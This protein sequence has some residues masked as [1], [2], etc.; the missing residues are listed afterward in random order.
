[1]T[2]YE[3]HSFTCS[4]ELN[5]EVNKQKISHERSYLLPILVEIKN[6]LDEH[7]VYQYPF[8]SKTMTSVELK[9]F[10]LHF[11]NYM[12]LPKKSK[13]FLKKR[14]I[15]KTNASERNLLL[16]RYVLDYEKLIINFLPIFYKNHIDN[17]Q[18]NQKKFIEKFTENIQFVKNQIPPKVENIDISLNTFDMK[19][20]EMVCDNDDPSDF[21]NDFYFQ[22]HEW[23][24]M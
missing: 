8:F 6:Y 15:N 9:K 23:Q 2:K 20:Y 22:D 7:Y 16:T 13:L 21:Q 18:Q 12:N 4:K 1:M 24:L 17:N 11:Q 3:K 5:A 10:I 14:N 19:C